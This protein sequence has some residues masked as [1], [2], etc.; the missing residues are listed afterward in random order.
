MCALM[1]LSYKV[2][3][4]KFPP[5]LPLAW[6]F[7]PAAPGDQVTKLHKTHYRAVWRRRNLLTFLE[8][9][10]LLLLWPL[11]QA[12]GIWRMTQQNGARIK[13]MTG[14][15]L[16]R[17]M[18]E[19]VCV[20][21][22]FG[23]RPSAYYA[24]E[25]FLPERRRMAAGYVH[26]FATKDSLYRMLAPASGATLT[27]KVGFASYCREQHLPAAPV[28][29]ALDKGRVVTEG[30]TDLPS[31]DL[32]VKRTRG[33]GGSGAEVWLHENGRYRRTGGKATQ[34]EVLDGAALVARLCKLATHEPYLVQPCMV[35]HPDLRDL[36]QGALA[37]VRLITALDE[38]GEPQPIRAVF[39]MPSRA[40]SVVDN[41]H[42]GGIATAIDLATGI[43]GPA[44][45]RGL[46]GSVG[47][48]DRHPI[49]GAEI[50]GR[51][52]PHWPE[53]LALALRAHRAYPTRIFIGWDIA[54][55]D[56]GLMI[57]EGNA[58][59]D[60][61]IVQRVHRSPLS[62]T[63]YAELMNWHIAQRQRPI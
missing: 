26:R 59:T 39:R 13:A 37:T 24:M 9:V 50:T 42:A 63:R 38:Q 30:F 36:C 44:T 14:K 54:D 19:Q 1:A 49:S 16:V 51:T 10:V 2:T 55:T 58:A 21:A 46:K 45:D 27:D 60:T 7:R 8:M 35:N 18:W 43:M 34:H 61:D 28:I 5:P 32:F 31:Q 15:S 40:E 11:L 23:H 3:V 56:R 41:F 33:R 12:P 47:W 22:R 4:Q 53:I 20:A 29:L 62:E 57:V 52:L 6:A 48:V 25:F 17:Q